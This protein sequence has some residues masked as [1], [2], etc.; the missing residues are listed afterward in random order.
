MRATRTASVEEFQIASRFE[1]LRKTLGSDRYRPHREK[2]L[3]YWALPTD[4][5]L[6][7]ILLGRTLQEL[8]ATPFSEITATPGIG[9]KK[10]DSFVN[11][12]SRAATTD[13][14]EL[15]HERG[16]LHGNGHGEAATE[17]GRAAK[18]G[19][20]PQRVS[21][22]VWGKWRASVVKRGLGQ[23]KLGHLASSLQHMT[24]VDWNVP[25]E[26]YSGKT[27]AEIRSM[28]THGEKRVRAILEV[29]H[30]VHQIV[31]D[32]GTPSHLAVRILPQR[33]DALE[34]WIDRTLQSPRVPDDAE[35][36]DRFVSV[37]LEQLR[38]DAAEQI[39]NLAR[40]RLGLSGPIT[41]VRETARTMGLTRARIYQLLN[42]INDIIL[43]R[44]PNGR[45]RVY[46]LYDKLTADSDRD[47]GSRH[48][49]QFRAAVELFYPSHRRGAD[50]ALDGVAAAEDE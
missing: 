1:S 12:L 11:L 42:E 47:E 8:L 28:K 37:L 25:L 31:G 21:E 38:V 35:I 13:P 2:P 29:F 41:S 27:L 30:G 45:H 18:N 24:R 6:P 49:E 14:V 20:D 10:I 26:K 7:L 48:L 40:N 3:A 36:F 44:W 4:R 9:R 23:E 46:G 32:M 19:F 43:V 15:T 33:I 5:R 16:Q 22:I 39:M 17:S 34:Q 50:G